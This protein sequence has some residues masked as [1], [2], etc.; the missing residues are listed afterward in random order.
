M[1]LLYYIL[2]FKDNI[3]MQSCMYVVRLRRIGMCVAVL[4]TIPVSAC[5][6]LYTKE[7][8]RLDFV[9]CS[10]HTCIKKSLEVGDDV[11]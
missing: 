10:I 4:C 2:E 8:Y 9:P 5:P 7:N 6:L 11:S 1:I 3:H